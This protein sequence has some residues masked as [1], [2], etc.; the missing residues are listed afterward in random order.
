MTTTEVILRFN[1][2][3]GLLADHSKYYCG[4]TN[5]LELRAQQH[6]AT[7]LD[8]VEA[9]SVEQA[10]EIEKA[11]QNVGYDCGGLAGNAHEEDSVYVYI[12]KKGL[13]TVE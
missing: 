12:Y 5:D 10:N 1:A 7:F 2:R 8:Y 4:I 11:L 6:N 13:E 3:I 9:D